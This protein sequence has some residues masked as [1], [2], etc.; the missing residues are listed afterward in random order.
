M[1]AAEALQLERFPWRAACPKS[2]WGVNSQMPDGRRSE[3]RHDAGLDVL[4]VGCARCGA[5]FTLANDVVTLQWSTIGTLREDE[6]YQ[7][8]IVDVTS[9]QG[10]RTTEYVTDNKFIVST[11]FRPNDN[12]AHVIRWWVTTVR[13]TGVDDQ[14]QPV[15]TSAGAVSEERVFSWVGVAVQASPNP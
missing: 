5:A 14:G 15:Y 6:R 2:R 7:V 12:L 4:W 8:T 1:A 13:Q 9:G 11:N 3:L 10:L